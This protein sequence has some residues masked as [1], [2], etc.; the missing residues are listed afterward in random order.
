MRKKSD[1]RTSL[2][3]TKTF[4][5]SNRSLTVGT[6]AHG[7][8]HSSREDY[9]TCQIPAEK[10]QTR[11]FGQHSTTIEAHKYI[12]SPCNNPSVAFNTLLVT[13]AIDFV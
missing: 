5:R 13:Q 9:L 10:L 12:S 6:R 4:P 2:A 7:G 1:N 3:V 8:P 11:G